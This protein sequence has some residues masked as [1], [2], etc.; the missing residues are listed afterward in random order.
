MRR[1]AWLVA[2]ALL[3]LVGGVTLS[4]CADDDYG[5]GPDLAQPKDLSAAV[6]LATAD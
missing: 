1:F 2:A 4:A 6:D 5:S 3:V